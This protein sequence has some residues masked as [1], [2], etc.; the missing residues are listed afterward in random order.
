MAVS[1]NARPA[2]AGS[3]NRPVTR[4]APVLIVISQRAPAGRHDMIGP[5]RTRPRSG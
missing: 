2:A 5:A 4:T 1:T 3:A